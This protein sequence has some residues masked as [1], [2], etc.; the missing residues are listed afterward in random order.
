VI[1]RERHPGDPAKRYGTNTPGRGD[2][3]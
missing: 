1:R 2:N 3:Q